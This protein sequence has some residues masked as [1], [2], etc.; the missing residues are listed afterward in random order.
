[1]AK[2]G[3]RRKQDQAKAAHKRAEQARRKTR[4]ELARQANLTIRRLLDPQTPPARWRSKAV[5]RGPRLKPT[6]SP[7]KAGQSRSQLGSR[8]GSRGFSRRSNQPLNLEPP[9]GIEPLTFSLPWR[10]SAD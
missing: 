7:V 1:V 4:D 3:K 9:N 10:R 2:S 5:R 6:C 8:N